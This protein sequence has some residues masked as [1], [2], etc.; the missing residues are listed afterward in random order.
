MI[1]IIIVAWFLTIP[2]FAQVIEKGDTVRFKINPTSFRQQEALKKE[3]WI[4]RYAGSNGV[5]EYYVLSANL[6]GDRYEDVWLWQTYSFYYAESIKWI[7]PKLPEGCKVFNMGI[8]SSEDRFNISVNFKGLPCKALAKIL[9]TEKFHIQ[10]I[11][12][13]VVDE[14]TIVPLVNFHID[15]LPEIVRS[16]DLE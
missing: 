2:L 15:D 10:Y 6:R 9:M 14:D 4:D 13:P 16:F 1:K 11:N 7:S 12:V 5:K 8:G 3:I